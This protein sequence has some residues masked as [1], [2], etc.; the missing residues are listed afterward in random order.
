MLLM[1]GVGEVIRTNKMQRYE[2]FLKLTG[3]GEV[4][5][6]EARGAEVALKCSVDW[7]PIMGVK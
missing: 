5:C 7:T 1:N 3:S 6:I 4:H 2:I